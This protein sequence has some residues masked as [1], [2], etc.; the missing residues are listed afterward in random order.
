MR[1][2]VRVSAGPCFC[3]VCIQLKHF[4]V[5]IE[6][7]FV[8]LLKFRQLNKKITDYASAVSNFIAVGSASL[9]HCSFRGVFERL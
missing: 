9:F 2:V 5:K 7:N 1:S 4:S 8:S 6:L 3:S